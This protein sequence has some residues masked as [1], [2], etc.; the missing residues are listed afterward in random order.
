MSSLFTDVVERVRVW[1]QRNEHH[2]VRALIVDDEEPIRRLVD[3]V[4]REAGIETVTAADGPEAITVFEKAGNIDIL[5]TDLMMPG[6]NGDE[7]GRRVR[8]RDPDLRVLYLTGFSDRLFADKMMLWDNEAFLD[9]PCSMQGLLEAVAL[10]LSG[11]TKLPDV[12]P[13]A[14]VADAVGPPPKR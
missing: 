5:V 10:L 3:R 7:L 6:M 8:Q 14:T 4:L 1:A 13:N 12:R 2:T 9:K 11:R